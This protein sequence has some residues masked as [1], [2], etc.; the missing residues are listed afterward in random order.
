MR[1]VNNDRSG[2]LEEQDVPMDDATADMDVLVVMTG[3]DG[4]PAFFE[5]YGKMSMDGLKDAVDLCKQ[6]QVEV[7]SLMALKQAGQDLTAKLQLYLPEGNLPRIDAIADAVCAYR[8]QRAADTDA[9]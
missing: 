1:E 8:E 4:L 6:H 3:L 7:E 2:L 5:K 9:W